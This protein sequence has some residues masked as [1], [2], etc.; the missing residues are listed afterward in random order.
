MSPGIS[1]LDAKPRV[2]VL[3]IGIE[4]HGVASAMRHD[5]SESHV[6]VRRVNFLV[7]H[8]ESNPMTPWQNRVTKLTQR[9]ADDM[10]LR[11]FSQ[12]TIDAYT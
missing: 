4:E 12:S 10:K 9:M 1:R 8:S 6:H 3:R 5:L 7:V 2:A 11:K